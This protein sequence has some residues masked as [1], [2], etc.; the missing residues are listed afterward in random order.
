MTL[1]LRALGA[2]TAKVDAGHAADG[3]GVRAELLVD[4]VVL[5]LA[6][7]PQV[8]FGQPAAVRVRVAPGPLVAALVDRVKL[9]VA[10]FTLVLEHELEEVR[11]ADLPHRVPL[12]R[13]G[14]IHDVDLPGAGLEDPDCELL[15]TG[16]IDLV[17]SE[18]LEWIVVIAVDDASDQLGELG[19]E[20]LLPARRRVAHGKAG[21][22]Y[23]LRLVPGSKP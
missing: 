14:Q 12:R 20:I 15:A 19:H 8:V 6:E 23:R 9:V 21:R 4:V 13:V 7:E 10:A 11:L 17:R 16:A 22:T 2:Q 1:T 18:D 3:A 5:P